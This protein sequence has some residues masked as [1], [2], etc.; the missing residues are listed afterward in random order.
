MYIITSCFTRKKY[1]I[2]KFKTSSCWG[3]LEY[4]HRSPDSR[5]R[6]RKGNPV[7]ESLTGH[8]VTGGH[9]YKDLVLQ[10]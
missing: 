2:N 8:L 4:L 6:W 10:I 3:G 1:I 5:R 9:E 7:P